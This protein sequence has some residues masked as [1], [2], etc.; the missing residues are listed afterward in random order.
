M[1]T[2][3]TDDGYVLQ[4]CPNCGRMAKTL[5]SV[6]T[7]SGMVHGC[8]DCVPDYKT[9]RQIHDERKYNRP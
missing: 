3:I 2:I 1:F 6:R 8:P 9:L 7:S 4:R 5:C